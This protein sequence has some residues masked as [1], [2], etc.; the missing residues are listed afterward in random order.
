MN[1]DDNLESIKDRIRKIR[2]HFK[3]TQSKL[4]DQL[5]L[6]Q[7]TIAG[8]ELGIREPGNAVISLICREFGVNEVWL[9]TGEGGDE[10]MFTKISADDRYSISLGKL[11]ANENE[12]VQNAINTLAETNPDQLK[13][14]EDF[15]KKCLGIK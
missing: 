2:K 6:K 13:I 15:M 5:G 10:N 9:R 8:Y 11:A 14:I 4:G 7:N 3:I 12:F 1:T